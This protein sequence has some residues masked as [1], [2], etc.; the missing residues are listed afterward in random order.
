MGQRNGGRI[1][2]LLTAKREVVGASTFVFRAAN[3]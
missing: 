3:S 1:V 2:Q